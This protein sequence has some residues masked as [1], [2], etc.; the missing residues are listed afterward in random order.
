MAV[1]VVM[2][3]MVVTVV[4]AAARGDGGDGG[5]D[6]ASG[7]DDDSPSAVILDARCAVRRSGDTRVIWSVEGTATDP[8]G[9][10]TL[11]TLVTTASWSL[12]RR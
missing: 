2:V 8:Q 7:G 9:A 1:T 5:D 11:K 10:D 6:A 3:V 12:R 4:T